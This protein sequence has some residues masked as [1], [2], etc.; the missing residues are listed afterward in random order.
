MPPAPQDDNESPSPSPSVPAPAASAPAPA[1]A[2]FRGRDAEGA[3]G[4]EDGNNGFALIPLVLTLLGL[5]PRAALLMLAAIL[6]PTA[7]FT[8]VYPWAAC[9]LFGISIV[10]LHSAAFWCERIIDAKAYYLNNRAFA[11]MAA[12]F[13]PFAVSILTRLVPE[14]LGCR[15]DSTSRAPPNRLRP[16]MPSTAPVPPVPRVFP[17]S[18]RAGDPSSAPVPIVVLPPSLD[19]VLR[20][21]QLSPSIDAMLD[22][23]LQQQGGTVSA[24][25]LPVTTTTS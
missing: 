6:V 7:A 20:Q 5:S 3:E 14:I 16:S 12:Q 18:P 23:A 19:A 17:T 21:Q 4:A 9:T 8:A 2:H 25:G 15:C 22:A 24:T 11:D 1:P 13:T 10:C